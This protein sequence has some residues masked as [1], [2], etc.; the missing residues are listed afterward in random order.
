MRTYCELTGHPQPEVFHTNEGHAGFL[1]LERI[2]E[3]IA[4]EGLDF[5]EALSAVRAGHRVHHAHPGARPAST[6]SRST[7]CALLRRRQPAA[8]RR[9]CSRVLA[10][11]AEDNPGMF[12]M[13]HMGLRLAQ[14]A[15]GVSAA[16]RPGR[17]QMFGGLWP[18]FDTD[19]VPISSVT[20][21]VHGPTWAAREITALLGES[22]V[23]TRSG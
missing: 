23:D 3:L 13:A 6:G 8:R 9:R 19:E 18:G 2:R 14:R 1:G 21:G 22:E 10:L 11:G 15:N 16:A 12:N 20:N 4:G 5:D 17:R 7:W